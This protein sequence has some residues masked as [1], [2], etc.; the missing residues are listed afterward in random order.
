M[1]NP[2]NQVPQ[3]G[4]R[5]RGDLAAESAF[6]T[7]S[8]PGTALRNAAARLC[9]TTRPLLFWPH[10]VPSSISRSPP[11]CPGNAVSLSLDPP[12]RHH[13][14]RTLCRS[15]S[16]ALSERK[17][18][19]WFWQMFDRSPLGLNHWL[20]LRLRSMLGVTSSSN[21]AQES[22]STTASTLPM[23]TRSYHRRWRHHS[24]ARAAQRSRRHRHRQQRRVLPHLFLLA[25][26]GGLRSRSAARTV[27]PRGAASAGL[28][29]HCSRRPE[30][31]PGH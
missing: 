24:P 18:L 15:R 21:S 12:E 5:S 19:L 9:A 1:A 23:A 3:L 31:R 6:S 10:S 13:G 22:K 7:R 17:P 27:M 16:P 29:R 30:R 20:G 4:A 11:N 8:R 2:E 14:S 25:R 28:S 26:C